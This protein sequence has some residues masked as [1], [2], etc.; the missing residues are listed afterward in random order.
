MK[1]W[2][3]ILLLCKQQIAPQN[4]SKLVILWLFCDW[5]R[6]QEEKLTQNL[7]GWKPIFLSLPGAPSLSG[8]WYLRARTHA[9]MHVQTE[10]DPIAAVSESIV[11]EQGFGNAS[12]GINPVCCLVF[13]PL[14]LR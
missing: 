8:D 3:V 7:E 5:A 12:R 1:E 2:C 4:C 14:D 6:Q 10:S 11:K 9:R 13:Y